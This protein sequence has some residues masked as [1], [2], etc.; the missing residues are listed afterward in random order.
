MNIWES[1]ICMKGPEAN[2]TAKINV[3]PLSQIAL[4]FPYIC[5]VT[6][7]YK[8]CN[9]CTRENKCWALSQTSLLVSQTTPISTFHVMQTLFEFSIKENMFT[10]SIQQYDLHVICMCMR[11]VLVVFQLLYV[12]KQ[13]V[14]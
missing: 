2:A 7:C 13:S 9:C 5:C 6:I 11:Y 8:C 12:Q 10:L 4:P 3:G 1:A 14:A